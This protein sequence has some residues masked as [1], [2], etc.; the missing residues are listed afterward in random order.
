MQVA[1]LA[2]LQETLHFVQTQ[3][4]SL[5][6]IELCHQVLVRFLIL[7]ILVSDQTAVLIE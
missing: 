1:L 7:Q 3:V 6:L 5:K 2:P 4:A